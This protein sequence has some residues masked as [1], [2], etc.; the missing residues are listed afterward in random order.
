MFDVPESRVK[1]LRLLGTDYPVKYRDVYTKK[2]KVTFLELLTTPFD[3]FS[4]IKIERGGVIGWTANAGLY[5]SHRYLEETLHDNPQDA[6]TELEAR[7]AELTQLS[8]KLGVPIRVKYPTNKF[9]S[10]LQALQDAAKQS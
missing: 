7:L 3:D 8:N 6:M 2:D 4:L 9:E 5:Y 10:C 1:T